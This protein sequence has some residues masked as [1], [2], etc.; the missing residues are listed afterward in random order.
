[1]HKAKIFI[2]FSF[3]KKR[4]GPR[5]GTFPYFPLGMKGLNCGQS[6]PVKI[7]DIT[8]I[9]CNIKFNI[10]A[11]SNVDSRIKIDWVFIMQ[12]PSVCKPLRARIPSELIQRLGASRPPLHIPLLPVV[13][14]ETSCSPIL[15]VPALVRTPDAEKRDCPLLQ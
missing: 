4:D 7:F 10:R 9:G 8:R 12:Q 13:V 11:W 6:G 2:F 5:Q 3:K 15:I 1:M 14:E